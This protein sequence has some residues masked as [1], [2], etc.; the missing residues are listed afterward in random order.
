[1]FLFIL[2]IFKISMCLCSKYSYRS[3]KIFCFFVVFFLQAR[4][5]LGH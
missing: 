4:H 5:A 3:I 1:M 2:A